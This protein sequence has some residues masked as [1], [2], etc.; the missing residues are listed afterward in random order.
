MLFRSLRSLSKNL[1]LGYD[2]F[3]S[4]V[5]SREGQAKNIAIRLVELSFEHNLPIVIMGESYK[6]HVDYVDGSF[7]KLIG[8][9]LTEIFRQNLEY[10]KI[11]KPSLFLLG[12][13]EVFNNTIFPEGSVV[14]DPW[15]ER[16]NN[17]T[18]YYGGKRK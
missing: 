9:Y 3:N 13:R 15:R 14:L 2:L 4:I 7:S 1:S 11:D 8:F 12:H 6:P 5:E 17:D 18:I 16:N 10:D